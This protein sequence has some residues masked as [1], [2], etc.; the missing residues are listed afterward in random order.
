VASKPSSMLWK[1]TGKDIKDSYLF[2]TMHILK[3]ADFEIKESVKQAFKTADQ[4][5][6]EVDL[7]DPATQMGMMQHVVMRDGQTI[8]KLI[9]EAIY[10]QLDDN[11]TNNMGVGI[12]MFK[13]WQ[14]MMLMSM[15]LKDII[16]AQPASF[17]LTLIQ[18]AEAQSIEVFG[19]E[20]AEEQLNFFHDIPYKEQAKMIEEY[21]TKKEETAKG[22]EDLTRYY[23][24]GD[25]DELHKY[26]EEESKKVNFSTN[27]IID[28]RNKSWIPQI[29]ANAAKKPTF[30]AVG[31]GHLGGPNGVVA[32]LKAK[33]YKP[34]YRFTKCLWWAGFVA[35]TECCYYFSSRRP[36]CP[37]PTFVFYFTW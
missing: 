23:L 4:L 21:L 10:Q 27:E 1:I 22:F 37:F 20:T 33:G 3:Q 5:V 6:L 19:L 25:I 16:G 8:D 29:E 18:M 13:T 2:G 34:R 11:L 12:E 30:F 32:L 9:P 15:L 7:G 14:P 17:E 31:A 35:G 24:A 28:K 26:A 36:F